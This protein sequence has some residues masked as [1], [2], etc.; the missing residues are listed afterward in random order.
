MT[1]DLSSYDGLGREFVGGH[2]VVKHSRGE[3][4]RGAAHTNTA[5]SFF[6]LFK[7]G[8]HGTFHHI[9][10]QHLSRYANEFSFRWD[11]R[12]VDDGTRMVQAIAE[13]DG[14]RLMYR[15]GRDTLTA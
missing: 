10:K 2:Q 5:E 3:Y 14:K 6:A 8:V 7:R 1:D 13:T 9:S 15:G 11:H 12:K 4:V